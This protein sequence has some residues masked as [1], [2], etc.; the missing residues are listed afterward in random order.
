MGIHVQPREIDV[1]PDDPFKHDLL[2]RREAVDTLTHLVANLDGACTLAVDAAWGAG[3]TT[4]LRIWT[5]HLRNQGFPVVMFNAWETDYSEVPFVALST[6]LTEGLQSEQSK[7]PGGST[8]E[9]KQAS[10][11]V[12][13]WVISGAIRFAASHVPIVGAEV[14]V[15]DNLKVH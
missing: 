4:L 1:P 2:D 7:L 9:L 11:Q 8:D 10:M 6:E 5:Q 14:G 13:R 12:L 3:K 15:T